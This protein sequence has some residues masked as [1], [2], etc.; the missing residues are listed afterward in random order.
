M[1]QYKHL[2]EKREGRKLPPFVGYFVLPLSVFWLEVMLR[3]TA[4]LGPAHLFGAL[5][6]AFS[7]G[8]LLNLFC[9]L[10]RSPKVN[11]WIVFGLV[12]ALTIW[13]LIA[14]FTNNSYQVFMDP[15]SIFTG[16]GDVVTGF[17]E[18]LLLVIKSGI[19]TIILYHVPAILI[20]VFWKKLMF[21]REGIRQPILLAALWLALWGL[22]TLSV[23]RDPISKA[24]YTSEYSY[25]SAVRTF[26]A[27][28]ALR[29]DVRY[30][31]FG[32]PYEAS[33]DPSLPET[34]D[35][36]VDPETTEDPDGQGEEQPPEELPPEP[37]K[38]YEPN[39]MDIDF[40]ALIASTSDSTVK[41]LHEYV[42]S[43]TPSMQNDYT[44]MFAG[45]NLIL[46]TAEAFSKEVIDPVRTPTLYRLANQGIV[47]EDYYQPAWGG[48]T[49]TGEYSM[50]MGLV[51]TSGVKSI[52]QTVG[53]NMYFTM[54]NQ[55][56][57]LGYF[58]RAYHDGS[59]TYYSRNETHENLGYEKFIG[60]GNGM[61]EGVKNLWPES[62]LEMMQFT[63]D[64]YIDHQPFSVYYMTVSGHCLYTRTGNAM[65]KRNWEEMGEMSCSD[66]VKGYYS[67]NM[68]LEK[69]M[70][71]LVQRLEEAGIADDTVIALTTDHY[72]Y[73]LEKSASWGNEQDY[74][75]ELY[76][77]SAAGNVARDHSALILWSGC[78][79]KL[80]EPIVVSAPTYSLDIVP[81][82]SNL[83][84]V[85]YDSRMLIGRD[86]LSDEEPIVLWADYS[87]KT[88]KGYYNARSGSFTPNEGE[89]ADDAYISR[90]KSAVKNKINFSK[91]VL[92]TDY[93]GI[94][95]H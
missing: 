2:Q 94:L 56:S 88:E 82:L 72:P 63:V 80:E 18:T 24:Q 6:I 28:T 93:Y 69:A 73:G 9:T 13:F 19:F 38:V 52:R 81:T 30:K 57:R 40:D 87:W 11:S 49:S 79:E 78:L 47:F 34:D 70:T 15:A 64:Q 66:I 76:G 26:G 92:A 74:L 21:T 8:A 67:C 55:L 89:T 31:L 7:T 29:L 50:I 62:D 83:F 25:D 91:G 45:K 54:G 53:H 61:E 36:A 48:S 60:M 41:G 5:L 43:L 58:S 23:T 4:H 1:T 22:G 17:G 46:I 32:N 14:Y 59:Y 68:E 86:V 20:L 84:G 77:F 85:E 39:K 71:Y 16:A 37:P 51:P 10:S 35:P 33:F 42:N 12:E 75:S 27:L 95:F 44:G 90:I 3:L 65:A